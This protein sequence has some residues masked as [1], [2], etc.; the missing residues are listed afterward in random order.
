MKHTPIQELIDRWGEHEDVSRAAMVLEWDQETSMPPGG[1]NARGIQLSTLAGLAHEKLTS[2]DFRTALRNAERRKGL[3]PRERAMVREAQR[4]HNR[5]ARIPDALVREL[6]LTQSRALEAWRKSYKSSDWRSFAG[7]LDAILRL[8]RRFADCIGYEGVPYDAHL[9]LFEAGATVEMLDPVLGE[10]KE[11]TVPILQGILRSKRRPNPKTLR[12]TFPKEKQLEFGRWIV[13]ELGFDFENGRIDLTT[14]PFC[15]SFDPADT[16]LTTR[17]SETDL[18]Y[19]LFS[20]LHE[21]G[22][23]LYEQG[24]DAAIVRTPI[25]QAVSLGI[26]ESQSRLYE[27]VV[28]RSREFW[29]H[30]LPALKKWFPSL[31]KVKLDDFVFAVNEVRPSFIRTEADEVTY[32]LHVILRYE[33]EKDLFAGKIKTKNLPEVWNAKMKSTLGITPRKNSEGVLQDVHWASGLF[34]YF[35]TYSLGNLYGAQFWV[36]A[37]KD[38]PGLPQK[39][40]QGKLGPL[41]EW[42]RRKIHAPGRTENAAAILKRT[43]G[44]SLSVKPFIEYI[45]E[46]YGRLYDLPGRR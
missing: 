38:I 42:L 20:L 15:T 6:A 4:E 22:H 35:P 18:G 1:A 39:I 14:H 36:R 5:A 21:A 45:E 19:C 27:N 12:G 30:Y 17:V 25:G 24:I 44:Q 46:K 11:A 32:N 9:D 43:T 28:G 40:S 31:A 29:S 13:S 33:L 26:H 37:K 34:G 41:R 16:R 8:K 23:G 3:K 2:R 10:L 7:H